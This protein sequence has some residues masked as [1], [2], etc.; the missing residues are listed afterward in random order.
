M[1]F[2]GSQSRPIT[3]PTRGR[4]KHGSH[5]ALLPLRVYIQGRVFDRVKHTVILFRE[6]FYMFKM[7]GTPQ[8]FNILIRK[9]FIVNKLVLL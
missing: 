2:D 8:S 1:Q 5:F 6:R 9:W 7:Q 3:R 4:I